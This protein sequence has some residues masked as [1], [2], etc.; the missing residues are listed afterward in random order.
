MPQLS[1]QGFFQIQPLSEVKG[2]KYVFMTSA[3]GGQLAINIAVDCSPQQSLD[4]QQNGSIKDLY[5]H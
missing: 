5:K 2:I 1:T 3:A 4:F